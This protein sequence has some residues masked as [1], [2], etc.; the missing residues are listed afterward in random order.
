M[1][2]DETNAG[3]EQRAPLTVHEQLEFK[4][5][6][7]AA[8]QEALRAANAT[9]DTDGV[10]TAEQRIRVI[11]NFI[12]N[13]EID[14]ARENQQAAK[15]DAEA[16]ILGCRR[17]LGSLASQMDDDVKRVLDAHAALADAVERLNDRYRDVLRTQAEALALADRFDM[18]VGKL[19][20]VH[21][22]AHRVQASMPRLADVPNPIRPIFE[23]DEYGMRS[24]RTY[25]EMRGTKAFEI[26]QAVGPKP[27]HPLTEMQQRAVDS[28]AAQAKRKPDT[29]MLPHVPPTGDFALSGTL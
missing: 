20:P 21:A 16:R 3:D 8:A 13:L 4:R 17:A 11:E 12:L 18:S 14:V 27:W 23:E 7:L 25:D 15:K 9:L 19:P 22:P 2:Q 26:I 5:A 24:R 28:M 29:S 1:A 6:E 10:V